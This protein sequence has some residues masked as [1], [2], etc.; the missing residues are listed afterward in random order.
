MHSLDE[1]EPDRKWPM[2]PAA[3]LRKVTVTVKT[4]GRQDSLLS[5]EGSSHQAIQTMMDQSM[6]IHIT[7]PAHPPKSDLLL[8]RPPAALRLPGTLP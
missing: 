4:P 5:K 6:L 1:Q 8:K 7:G 3:V 2:T